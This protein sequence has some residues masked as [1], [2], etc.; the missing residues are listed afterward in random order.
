MNP[1][2][3][4]INFYACSTYFNH[5][6]FTISLYTFLSVSKALLFINHISKFS[7]LSGVQYDITARAKGDLSSNQI[8]T[9][10]N[11]EEQNSIDVCMYINY[12]LNIMISP[13][14]RC[15]LPHPKC[16]RYSM[17]LFFIV[18]HVMYLFGV[19]LLDIRYKMSD[20]PSGRNII[21]YTK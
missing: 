2:V 16:V 18:K 17:T 6:L 19:Y 3:E 12:F 21:I 9:Q 7:C 20:I 14:I 10:Q 1:L 13:T 4:I 11:R 8:P 5:R 15:S